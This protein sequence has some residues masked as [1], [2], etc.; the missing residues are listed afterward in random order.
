MGGGVCE[1]VGSG[2]LSVCFVVSFVCFVWFGLSSFFVLGS[3]LVWVVFSGFFC[4]IFVFSSLFGGFGLLA[5]S[6]PKVLSVF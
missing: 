5:K 4:V 3:N 1:G 6:W 2:L